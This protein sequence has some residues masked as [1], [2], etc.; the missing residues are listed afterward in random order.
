MPNR[1][2]WLIGLMTDVARRTDN[3]IVRRESC[4]NV[5]HPSSLHKYSCSESLFDIPVDIGYPI[6]PEPKLRAMIVPCASVE[7]YKRVTLLY[8]GDESVYVKALQD[9]HS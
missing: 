9:E 2:H 3:L 7:V 6:L 8:C 5:R 1:C 4:E